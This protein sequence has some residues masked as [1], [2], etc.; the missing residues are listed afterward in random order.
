MIAEDRVLVVKANGRGHRQMTQVNKY[1]FP[2]SKARSLFSLNRLRNGDM[3]KA[4]IPKGKIAGK[5]IGRLSLGR[6]ANLYTGSKVV[7]GVNVKYCSLLQRA[8]G[9]GYTYIPI[10]V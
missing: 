10:A 2:R 9:Y 6:P 4:D 8:D 1:G 3:V 7:K 5:Y